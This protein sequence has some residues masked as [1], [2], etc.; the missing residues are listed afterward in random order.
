MH[1]LNKNTITPSISIKPWVGFYDVTD[2]DGA[3]KKTQV[4]KQYITLKRLSMKNL[5]TFLFLL[6]NLVQS[7]MLTS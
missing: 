4:T 1:P 6:Y 3:E 7:F 5:C 2:L